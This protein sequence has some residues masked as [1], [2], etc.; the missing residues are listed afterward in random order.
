MEKTSLYIHIPFCKAK[1]HYC[2]FAS[3]PGMEAL[4][5]PYF[6][7]L[8]QEIAL[9]G[10]QYST[11]SIQTMFIGGGTPSYVPSEYIQGLLEKVYESFSIEEDAEITIEANPGTL[12]P[13]KLDMY[14]SCGINRL[15][16][17]VQAWQNDLLSVL[18]RIHTIEEFLQNFHEAR[19]AGF[20]N[21]NIDLMFALPGQ[22]LSH[23]EQTLTS[24][25]EL[26]PEHISCY[27]LTI[28]E[29]TPFGKWYASGRL[30]KTSDMLDREMYHRAIA[31]LRHAG[32]FHYEISNFSRPRYEC[33]HNKVYW[34]CDSYIGIGAGAHS[35]IDGIRYANPAD[36]QQYL[37]V[38]NKG[39]LPREE[40]ERVDRQEAMKEHMI[41]GLRLIQGISFDEFARKF[42]QDVRQVFPKQLKKLLHQGLLEQDSQGIRLTC[43]GL[44]LANEAMV[45]FI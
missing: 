5:E 36:L 33:K 8:N 30:Q 22:T 26:H 35:Y 15:S 17:G 19:K 34:N 7:E 6:H 25:V 44:D 10:Q 37:S 42:G 21:I 31:L 29:E 27:S 20:D 9:Y 4:M 45:E 11:P 24:V 16:M 41:M 1:C 43:R 3:Y 32:Y 18:G 13:Q 2:D 28:E 38:L 12:T 23:W 14:R 39:I 40:L